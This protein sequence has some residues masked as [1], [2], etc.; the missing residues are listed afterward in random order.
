MTDAS[1]APARPVLDAWFDL[2]C[3][4]CHTA[5]GDLTALRERYG[6]RLEIRVRHFPLAKHRHAYAAAQAAEEAFAQG[7][8]E[9]YVEA[10]LPRG[11][12][13]GR[14]GEP[15]LLEVAAQLGLDVDEVETCLIDGRHLL[16]VDADQAEAKALGVTGT[17]SYVIAGERLDGGRSQEGLRERIA[18]RVDRLLG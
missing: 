17:P 4:D 8:G 10:L 18:Q 5:L 1:D 12:E 15:V 2:Q 9:E 16:A 13:L 3:P 6:P 14:R 11:A 7:R